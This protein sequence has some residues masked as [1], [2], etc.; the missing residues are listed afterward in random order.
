MS[1][2][3]PVRSVVVLAGCAARLAAQA[4]SD[5]LRL[6]EVVVSAT[7]IEESRR[8]APASLSVVGGDELRRQG[9]RF[10]SDWLRQVP[11]VMVVPTGSYGGVTSLFLRGGESDYAKVL[12]DGVPVNLPG[13]SVNLANLSTEHV[14]RIEVL[15]GP[16]SVLYGSDA[17]TGVVHILTRRGGGSTGLQASAGA[18]SFGSVDLRLA[19]GGDAGRLGWS[20]ALSRYA[21]DGF[22]AFNN[23]YRSRVGAGTLVWRPDDATETRLSVRRGAHRA[24]FPTDFAGVLSDSNQFGTDRAW[25]IGF[26]ASR[27]LSSSVRLGVAWSGYRGDLGF[28]DQ[29]DTPGDTLGFGFQ[30]ERLSAIRRHL[31]DARLL[32]QLSPGLRVA[33]GVEATSES[34]R[35]HAETRSDFGEGAFADTADFERERRNLA[36]YAQARWEAVPGLDVHLGGRWDD[37]EVFGAFGTWRV[38]LVYI[39]SAAWRGHIAAGSGFKQPSFAEQFAATPFE[40]GNPS[41][42]PERSVAWEAGVERSAA[43]RRGSFGLT[44][45]DQRFRDLIQYAFFPEEPS[46]HN[47]ARAVSRGLELS[48]DARPRAD[49]AL[50]IRWTVLHTEVGESGASTP[51]FLHGERLLRRPSQV[52]TL[53]GSWSGV[54]GASLHGELTRIGRRDDVDFREFPSVRATLGAHTLV[55]L[56]AA[57]PLLATASPSMGPRLALTARVDNLLD[58]SYET[59]IGFPGRGRALMLGLIYGR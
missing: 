30:Q 43:D 34:E 40:I 23:D 54:G 7:R 16:A 24:A 13:G 8:L 35:Q 10:V 11:G 29:P 52:L 32:A 31:V 3:I 47:V 25:T 42:R 56:S 41:L 48:G 46:Y 21:S 20:A 45:F 37:N 1:F 17:V 18:G 28:S 36:V 5:T 33:T 58:A 9:F 2:H 15:R 27:R 53:L 38:G 4:P 55:A 26:E 22:Y 14:E 6:D 12:I 39:P 57:V 50:G 49:V 59:I 44:Y 51:T 19:A